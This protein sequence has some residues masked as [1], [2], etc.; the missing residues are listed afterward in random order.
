MSDETEYTLCP[1]KSIKTKSF[2]NKNIKHLKES[3]FEALS[4]QDLVTECIRLQRHVNQLKNLLNKTN[5]PEAFEGKTS[6][7]KKKFKERPFDFNNHNKRHVF[8]KFL[9]LGWNYQGYISQEHTNETVENHLFE[10]LKTTK[11]IES[12]ETSNYHRCGRT[13]IGVSAF[14]QIASIDVRSNCT[15]GLGVVVNEKSKVTNND[16]QNEIN[17]IKLL[18]GA[19]PDEI[20][21]ICWSP[22]DNEMSARFDCTSRAYRYYFP[23]GDLDIELM[24]EA[25]KRL[26]GSHDFRN[27]CK[28]DVSNGVVTFFRQINNVQC[29]VLDKEI[30]NRYSTVELVIEGSSFLWHQIRCIVGLLF[31]IGQ[32]REMPGI[33]TELFNVDKFPCKP[34]YSMAAEIPLVLFD[35]QYRGV[36]KWNYDHIELEKLI[37]LMQDNWVKENTKATIIRRMMDVLEGEYEETKKTYV[38]NEKSTYRR[39]DIE[40]SYLYLQGNSQGY[41]TNYVKLT[42]R[43]ASASLEVR[44][45]HYVKKRRL[46]ADIYTKM[47]KNKKIADKLD[48][49]AK[50]AD[51]DKV[52]VPEEGQNDDQKKEEETKVMKISE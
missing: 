26:I 13:D 15:S 17:Y 36:D 6:K 51:Y 18:N 2:I 27:F 32:K 44:V 7:R 42:D 35:C 45:E 29:K 4:R 1:G 5:T 40:Q 52:V 46:D 39:K 31:L 25:G 43:L 14:S 49:Y 33:I 19:L 34:Q 16:I 21:A 28:M 48:L 20:R 41:T 22:I 50:E 38:H 11:L 47:E 12:R 3:D 24:N 23:K 37:K 8:I 10:A 9:Y 30:D